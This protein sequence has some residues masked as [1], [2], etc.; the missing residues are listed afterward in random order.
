MF[1]VRSVH[2]HGQRHFVLNRQLG[3]FT[4]NDDEDIGISAIEQKALDAASFRFDGNIKPLPDTLSANTKA[5]VIEALLEK[6][7]IMKVED[8]YIISEKGIRAI[9]TKPILDGKNAP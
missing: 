5:R 1:G 3:R 7:L 6:S 8:K 4:V 9:G 2:V